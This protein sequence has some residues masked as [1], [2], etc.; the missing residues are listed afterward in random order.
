MQGVL[1]CTIE[2]PADMLYAVDPVG[3]LMITPSPTKVV[4]ILSSINMSNWTEYGDGPLSKTI[5]FRT[6]KFLIS[7]G[8]CRSS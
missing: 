4:N 6:W 8:S 2:P 1:A 3:V 5:S 7:I